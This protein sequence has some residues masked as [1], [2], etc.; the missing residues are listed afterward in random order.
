LYVLYERGKG[1]RKRTK[2]KTEGDAFV[3]NILQLVT[4][5]LEG[6]RMKNIHGFRGI[7]EESGSS[8]GPEKKDRATQNLRLV[9][10]NSKEK[11]V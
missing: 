10:G 1:S 7:K 5:N 8:I 11:A 9:E 6:A 2:V 3:E 4:V